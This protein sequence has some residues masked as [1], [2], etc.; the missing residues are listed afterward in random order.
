[1]G[2]KQVSTLLSVAL[3]PLIASVNRAGNYSGIQPIFL[4]YKRTHIVK[5]VIS[6]VSE[7]AEKI[8]TF[9]LPTLIGCSIFRQQLEQFLQLCVMLRRYLPP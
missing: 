4:L 9:L 5:E 6:A 2:E 8:S 7:N 3:K 1:M